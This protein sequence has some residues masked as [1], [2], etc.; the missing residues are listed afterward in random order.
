MPLRVADGMIEVVKVVQKLIIGISD[1]LS[2]ALIHSEDSTAVNSSFVE[3]L[4]LTLR[5]CCAYLGR[6]RLSHTREQKLLS[7]HLELVRWFYNFM[8]PHRAL[9][10]GKV[11][12]TPAMQAGLVMKRLRFHDLFRL[13]PTLLTHI[14]INN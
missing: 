3:R 7:D 1:Q 8:R 14:V 2:Q 11:V 10:F 6:R 4:N 12:R 13:T 9:K 5:Q